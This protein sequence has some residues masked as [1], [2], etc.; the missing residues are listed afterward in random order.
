[1]PKP[2][3]KRSSG[4]PPAADGIQLVH[5]GDQNFSGSL[6]TAASTLWANMGKSKVKPAGD[7]Y[8]AEVNQLSRNGG[9][10][11]QV[12]RE[13]GRDWKFNAMICIC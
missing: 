6:N 9:W 1:M 7:I 5:L 10:E 4:V 8:P 13:C 12:A 3:E 2:I 11:E